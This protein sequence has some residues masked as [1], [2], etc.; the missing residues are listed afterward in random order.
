MYVYLAPKFSCL[1]AMELKQVRQKIIKEFPLA[2]ITEYRLSDAIVE[3]DYGDTDG[4]FVE[5]WSTWNEIEDWQVARCS[6]LFSFAPPKAISYLIPR[7]MIF[8]L[9][10]ICG[11]IDRKSIDTYS[12]DCLIWYL[13]RARMSGYANQGFTKKQIDT[14]ESF[15]GEIKNHDYYRTVMEIG[16]RQLRESS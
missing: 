5:D 8:V 13:Q 2:P 10:D 3:D 6:A 14:I 11:Y 16:E 1:L 12:G 4:T 7:Y 15:L 9:D